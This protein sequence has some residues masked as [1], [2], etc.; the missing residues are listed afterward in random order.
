MAKLPEEVSKAWDERNGPAVLTT[1][2]SAGEPNAIYV[3][4]VS[5]F[6]ED[7]LV[8]ADNGAKKLA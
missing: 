6:A 7:S 4:C 2:D 8:V 5:K 1:V 3:T